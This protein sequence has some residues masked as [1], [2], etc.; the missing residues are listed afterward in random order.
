[1]LLIWDFDVDHILTANTIAV[2]AVVPDFDNIL[3]T[4]LLAVDVVSCNC[5]NFPDTNK[6]LLPPLDETPEREHSPEPTERNEDNLNDGQSRNNSDD[7]HSDDEYEQTEGIVDICLYC[8]P[9]Y[10]CSEYGHL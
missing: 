6:V 2:A 10:I 8:T 3:E 9:F 7:E 4:P 1:M 5:S